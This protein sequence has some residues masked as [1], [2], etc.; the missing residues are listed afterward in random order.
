MTWFLDKSRGRKNR[1]TKH[2]HPGE[3]DASSLPLLPPSHGGS[4]VHA[5]FGL[6][7]QAPRPCLSVSPPLT[8][9]SFVCTIFFYSEQ[10]NIL[11]LVINAFMWSSSAKRMLLDCAPRQR[12]S[13]DQYKAGP[14]LIPSLLKFP[15]NVQEKQ[16]RVSSI[17]GH[18]D[19]CWNLTRAE[20]F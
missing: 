20:M 10:Y 1:K 4:F 6:F 18:C 7:P 17:T 15:A 13:H 16:Q 14:Q 12:T 11:V 9:N 5:P 3:E 8:A 19:I 2:I